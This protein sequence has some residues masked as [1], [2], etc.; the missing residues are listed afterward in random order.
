MEVPDRLLS[1][2][3]AVEY[4]LREGKQTLIVNLELLDL[5]LRGELPVGGNELPPEEVTRRLYEIK[6]ERD[7]LQRKLGETTRELGLAN[8]RGDQA[9]ALL[10]ALKALG[11]KWNW[12]EFMP[13]DV[14]FDQGFDELMEARAELALWKPLT[15]AEAEM[16]LNEAKAV[17]WSEDRI[18]EIVTRATDPAEK[19]PNSHQ[20]QLAA[21]VDRL[22]EK[23]QDEMYLRGNQLAAISTALMANTPIALSQTR[24][25]AD[26]ALYTAAF[27][28]AIRAVEEI[29]RLRKQNIQVRGIANVLAD[30]LARYT[31]TT[32]PDELRKAK[33]VCIE[34]NA[35]ADLAASGGIV[36]AP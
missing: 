9:E 2:R 21:E 30:R 4:G 6:A 8:V 36:D 17:P 28:D 27:Q 1:L 3:R 29:I 23:V 7:T 19:L 13:L 16:A 15:P 5:L 31:G 35:Y 20:A 10:A 24:L 32:V 14:Y 26:H 18:R 12:D 11:K 34:E 33:E 25:P 22:K